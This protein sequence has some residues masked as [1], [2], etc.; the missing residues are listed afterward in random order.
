MVSTAA[1]DLDDIAAALS[2]PLKKRSR[3]PLLTLQLAAADGV[4]FACPEY[5]YSISAALKNAI[6]WASRTEGALCVCQR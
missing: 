5:N 2:R 1:R 4:L 6:D 3:A